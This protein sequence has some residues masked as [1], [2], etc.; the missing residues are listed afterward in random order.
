MKT[1][2]DELKKKVEHRVTLYTPPA[3][4]GD[5]HFLMAPTLHPGTELLCFPALVHFGHKGLLYQAKVVQV[6]ACVDVLSQR[7]YVSGDTSGC[8]FGVGAWSWRRGFPMRLLLSVVR[9]SSLKQRP[10][11]ETIALEAG[12]LI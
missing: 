1:R 7:Q 10:T 4:P 8:V 2:E 5:K 11:E 6:L 9:K 3:V 12:S